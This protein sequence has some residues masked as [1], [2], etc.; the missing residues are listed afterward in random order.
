MLFKERVS[1]STDIM[2]Y[3]IKYINSK[4]NIAYL[5]AQEH[6]EAIFILE[7]TNF[8]VKHTRGIIQPQT[9]ANPSLAPLGI[10]RSQAELPL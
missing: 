2:Y 1:E 3:T 6:F 8:F 10:S 9:S 4:S 7:L 5:L